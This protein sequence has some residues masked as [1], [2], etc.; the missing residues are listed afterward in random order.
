MRG[1]GGNQNEELAH[2]S[3]S[4]RGQL[5]ASYTADATQNPAGNIIGTGILK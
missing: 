1:D 4:C 5:T 3:T 2:Q